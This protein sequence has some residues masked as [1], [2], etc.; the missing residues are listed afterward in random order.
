MIVP[1]SYHLIVVLG[2]E[3]KSPHHSTLL[4]SLGE[5]EVRHNPVQQILLM[6]VLAFFTHG[7]DPRINQGFGV[8]VP[9]GVVGDEEAEELRV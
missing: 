2:V 9:V 8:A 4:L 6:I 5:I 7:V 3:R 1:S